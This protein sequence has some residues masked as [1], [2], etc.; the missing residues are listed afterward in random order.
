MIKR[1]D[2]NKFVVDERIFDM[3]KTN[4]APS[5]L[6]TLE[7]VGEAESNNAA[8]YYALLV[9]CCLTCG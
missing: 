1:Q 8:G 2:S 5:L 7:K 3:I 9:G 4:Y 6:L